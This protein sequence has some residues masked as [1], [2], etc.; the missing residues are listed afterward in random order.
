MKYEEA[1]GWLRGERSMCNSFGIG[2][3]SI[4]KTCE[5]DSN[6]IQQAYWI[7]KAHKEGLISTQPLTAD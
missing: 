1:L 7:V 6:M 2:E 5:A 3:E 4:I